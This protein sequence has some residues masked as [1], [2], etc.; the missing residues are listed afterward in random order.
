MVTVGEAEDGQTGAGRAGALPPPMTGKVVVAMAYEVV[1]ADYVEQHR[2]GMPVVDVRPRPMFS[3]G[4]VPGALSIPFDEM[5]ASSDGD[6]DVHYGIAFDTAGVGRHDDAIVMCQSGLHAQMVCDMLDGL[7]FDHL[8]L[9]QGSW[10]DWAS[11]LSRPREVDAAVA[12][13]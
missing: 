8:K 2:E 13:A 4:H 9:Y 11:D 3:D 7:G 1:D 12:R 5:E 6:M 10:Q